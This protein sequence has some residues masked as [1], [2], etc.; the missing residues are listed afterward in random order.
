MEMIEEEDMPVN[1]AAKI[2]QIFNLRV[3]A[4]ES[5][6]EESRMII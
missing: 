6:T 1:P 2:L 4:T 3:T 5:T